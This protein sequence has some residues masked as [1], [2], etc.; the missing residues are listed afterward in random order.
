[1]QPA[2]AWRVVALLEMG[3]GPAARSELASFRRRW[4]ESRLPV[5]MW[6]ARAMAA[7]GALVDGR[8]AEA[9]LLAVEAQSRRSLGVASAPAQF[10]ASQLFEVRR[11]EDRL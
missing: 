7:T 3:D 10:F 1:A 9:A 6:H 11:Q 5:A 4:E 2:H 8:Y